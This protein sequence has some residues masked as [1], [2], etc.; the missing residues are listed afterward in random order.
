MNK[1][2]KILIFS[3]IVLL[4]LLLLNK[5][6][7]DKNLVWKEYKN[8]DFGFSISYPENWHITEINDQ[9]FPTIS[10]S[11]TK[12]DSGSGFRRNITS[13]VVLPN[14]FPTDGIPAE[15]SLVTNRQISS[16]SIETNLL[17]SNSKQ[18]FATLVKFS[19]RLHSKWSS[20]GFIIGRVEVK[21]Y[22]VTCELKKHIDLEQCDWTDG[23]I[24][25]SKGNISNESDRQTIEHM[26]NSFKFID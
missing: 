15:T 13:F 17:L 10:F 16:S 2:I 21:N 19:N 1:I 5:K 8:T 25:I 18:V 14:G 23:D 24:M 9:I 20:D 6:N 4:G 22:E 26:L 11:S 7:I 12:L 3:I